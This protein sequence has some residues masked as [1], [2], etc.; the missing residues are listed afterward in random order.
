[1]QVVKCSLKFCFIEIA[2]CEVSLDHELDFFFIV[3]IN[4][5]N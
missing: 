1:M 3:K 5:R 4:I 2:Q